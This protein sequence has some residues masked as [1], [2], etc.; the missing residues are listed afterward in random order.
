MLNAFQIDRHFLFLKADKLAIFADRVLRNTS[1]SPNFV[2]PAAIV[3]SVEAALKMLRDAINDPFMKR[4]D[5]PA[6]VKKGETAL[7][8]ALEGLAGYV[9]TSM[10][11]K[12][13]ILATGFHLHSDNKE[14]TR[15]QQ[16]M[17][18][19]MTKVGLN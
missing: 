13:D 18:A 2:K 4:K 14:N 7:L 5:R 1:Q 8:H 17:D 12:S 19:R 9:E 15:R 3:A 16:R 6:A 10:D 11:C